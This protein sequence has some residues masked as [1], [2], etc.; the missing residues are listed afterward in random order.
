[1]KNP[2]EP[3]FRKTPSPYEVPWPMKF[4]GLVAKVHAIDPKAAGWLYNEAPRL[5]G[6]KATGDLRG[7]LTW[8]DTPQGGLYWADIAETLTK[9][10]TKEEGDVSE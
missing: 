9:L 10:K 5:P 4:C 3:L 6:F 7:C 1:M 2:L 8:D